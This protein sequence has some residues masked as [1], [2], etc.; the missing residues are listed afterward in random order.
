M[1]NAT[2]YQLIDVEEIGGVIVVRFVIKQFGGDY[3]VYTLRQEL[4]GLVN[5]DRV[6]KLLLS[7]AG[8]EIITSSVLGEVINLRK[9]MERAG[10]VLK[11]SNMCPYIAEVFSTTKLDKKFDIRDDEAEALAAF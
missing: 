7:F 3:N 9:W 4:L 8:V 5:A 2:G 10:S 1:E 11:L 6:S